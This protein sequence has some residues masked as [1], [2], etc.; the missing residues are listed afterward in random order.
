[1][2]ATGSKVRTVIFVPVP[3]AERCAALASRHR[4]S[5][6]EVYRLAIEHGL[7]H[8][9]PALK[10]LERT[11]SQSYRPA[12]GGGLQPGTKSRRRDP[13]VVAEEGVYARLLDY[14]HS[15]LSVSPNAERDDV[16]VA[17][18]TEAKLL[19]ADDDGLDDVLDEILGE[20]FS[21]EGSP[22]PVDASDDA[23]LPPD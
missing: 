5:R 12:R 10:R 11:R 3:L 13:L 7:K 23:V 18:A 17:L 19:E 4:A 8:V 1:M 14:G 16:R 21:E 20:L 2:P 9:R 6:S 22:P 15:F